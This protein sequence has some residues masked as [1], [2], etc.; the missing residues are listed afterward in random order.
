MKVGPNPCGTYGP[1]RFSFLVKSRYVIC[2]TSIISTMEK[3]SIDVLGHRHA[4]DLV[5]VTISP[6]LGPVTLACP[7]KGARDKQLK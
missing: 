3:R 4:L 5:F 6:L 2:G 7:K 1:D